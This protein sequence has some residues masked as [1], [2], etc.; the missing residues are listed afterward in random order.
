M[1]FHWEAPGLAVP[2]LSQGWVPV[3]LLKALQSS[4]V[5]DWLAVSFTWLLGKEDKTPS[6]FYPQKRE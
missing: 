3:T 5:S 4:A 2:V 6:T 1:P